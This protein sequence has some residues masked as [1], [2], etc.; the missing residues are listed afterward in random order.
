MPQEPSP[1]AREPGNDRPSILLV[2]DNTQLLEMMEKILAT[3]YR[4]LTAENGLEA[5][6]QLKA[7]A[8]DLIGCHDAGHG[9]IR[10]VQET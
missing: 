2:D 4:V 10:L 1:E 7:S 9:R 6:K 5:L 3:K 8:V